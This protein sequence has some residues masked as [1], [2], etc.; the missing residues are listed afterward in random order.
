MYAG[1][2]DAASQAKGD[3]VMVNG[4]AAQEIWPG[5][6]VGQILENVVS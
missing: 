2:M 3:S 6:T 5:L 4:G 1:D